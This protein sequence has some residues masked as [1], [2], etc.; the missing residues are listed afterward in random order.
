MPP[1]VTI[2]IV[3]PGT[4]RTDGTN[5]IAGHIWYTLDRG[6]GTSPINYGFRQ[7]NGQGGYLFADGEVANN[8][9]EIY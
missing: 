6:D 4:P 1:S 8:D 9:H 3:G 7:A 5:S 2:N